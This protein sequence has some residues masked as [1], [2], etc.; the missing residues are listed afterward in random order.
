MTGYKLKVLSP[1][2]EIFDGE[3]ISL[4]LRGA[5]GDLAVFAGHI[6]FITTVK[7]GKCVI[8]L[9]DEKEI[10]GELTSGILDVGSDEVQLLI[11]DKKAFGNIKEAVD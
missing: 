10:E 7:P 11:G 5:D 9:P 6:P 4:L 3:V 1:D 2:G 8:T